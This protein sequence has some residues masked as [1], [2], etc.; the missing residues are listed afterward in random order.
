L[1]DNLKLY[2]K[3]N[4]GYFDNFT[5]KVKR[6]VNENIG[7][8]KA[9]IC[10]FLN[11]C[12]SP[13]EQLLAVNFIDLE[14]Q[15]YA[16]LSILDK[17]KSVH[18]EPQKEVL[19]N[20][21]KYRLDFLI[22]VIFDKNSFKFAIECDGHDFHER[23]KEQAARDKARERNLTM[24]GYRVVRFT[25]SEIWTDSTACISDLY[26]IICHETGLDDYYQELTKT[27]LGT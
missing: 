26:K 11:R 15:L 23:T 4:L 19:A 16:E 3:N 1:N 17:F 14:F 13:I 9:A 10:G 25:G 18:I 7:L 24:N 12:E 2:I 8:R 6:E 27:D 21:R 20:K 22:E 5:E